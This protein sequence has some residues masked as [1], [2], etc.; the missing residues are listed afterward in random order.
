MIKTLTLLL[1][2]PFFL[3]ASLI[4]Y[5]SYTTI[6]AVTNS[7]VTLSD[8][9]P[10]P[11]MSA[12]VIR[13]LNNTQYAIAYIKP[14]RSNS[15]RIIDTDPL[16]GGHLANIKPIVA[17]GDKVEAGFL[18]DKYMLL[19]PNKKA[20]ESIT[21]SFGLTPIDSELFLAYL[22]AKHKTTPN[23][24]DYKEFAKLLGIGLFIIAK[25]NTLELYDPISKAVIKKVAFNFDNSI[26]IKPFYTNL[27]Q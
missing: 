7:S 9:L 5:K 3:G 16:N 25:N 1:A 15:A 14:T 17:V 11:N 24:A 18:Y 22:K 4:P 12:L 13:N 19:A 20:Y 26:E 2:I 21:S 6:S 23:T 8:A 10:L 27:A